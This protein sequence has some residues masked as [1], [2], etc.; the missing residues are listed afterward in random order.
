MMELR[1]K[2]RVELLKKSGKETP[3]GYELNDLD[4]FEK[5][6]KEVEFS[7][8][9]DTHYPAV[10]EDPTVKEIEPEL[11]DSEEDGSRIQVAKHMKQAITIQR[12]N[13]Q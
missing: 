3:K 1:K 12:W 11:S 5:Q 7:T 6:S 8:F 13:T 10:S 9:M 2:D 4:S